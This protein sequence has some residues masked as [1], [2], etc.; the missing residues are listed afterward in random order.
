MN[1][2]EPKYELILIRKR[3]TIVDE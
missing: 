1:G 3:K 2:K